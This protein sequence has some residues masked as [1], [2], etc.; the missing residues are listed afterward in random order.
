MNWGNSTLD[1]R[2]PT[3]MK[4]R[5]H[6]EVT[7]MSLLQQVETVNLHAN[8]YQCVGIEYIRCD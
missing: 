4:E 5:A 6:R 7:W 1:V 2:E 3:L 8:D